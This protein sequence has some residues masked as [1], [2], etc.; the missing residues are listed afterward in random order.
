MQHT[1]TSGF[2]ANH[3][4]DLLI[5]K[6]NLKNDVEESNFDYAFFTASL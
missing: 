1:T 6:L 4:L 2:D 5:D 3:L